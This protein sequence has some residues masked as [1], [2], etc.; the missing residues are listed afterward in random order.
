MRETFE[1]FQEKFIEHW[2]K[3]IELNAKLDS[4]R[5]KEIGQD[6]EEVNKI[7]FEIQEIFSQLYPALEFMI[8]NYNLSVTAIN[9]YNTFIEDI[10]NAGGSMETKVAQS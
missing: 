1:L 10:K 5:G 7:L 8:K 6:V 4:Y 9:E 3:Y 2:K